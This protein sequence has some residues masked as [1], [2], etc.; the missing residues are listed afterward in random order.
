MLAGKLSSIKRDTPIERCRMHSHTQKP[1][2][3]RFKTFQ[4]KNLIEQVSAVRFCPIFCLCLDS[5]LSTPLSSPN[6]GRQ[7][8][9]RTI[10]VGIVRCLPSLPL[11]SPALSG[12]EKSPSL[13]LPGI[14]LRLTHGRSVRRFGAQD[15]KR[16]NTNKKQLKRQDNRKLHSIV[17]L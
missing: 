4:Y 10:I 17:P 14:H 13:S 15:K 5:P 2:G 1:E 12:L 9:L 16:H 7:G 8:T 6:S 11:L 3:F